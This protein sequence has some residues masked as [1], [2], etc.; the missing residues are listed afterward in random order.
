M[1][2]RL[3]ARSISLDKIKKFCTYRLPKGVKLKDFVIEDDD[4][5]QK[6]CLLGVG[7]GGLNLV[8]T[9]SKNRSN[10]HAMMAHMDYNDLGKRALSLFV[11]GHKQLYVVATLESEAHCHEAVEMIAKH[12]RCIGREVTL[13]IVEPFLLEVAHG[14]TKAINE[15]IKKLEAYTQKIVIFYH[16]DISKVN[17][18][19][20][21]MFSAIANKIRLCIE[22][23][24]CSDK[25]IDK[26]V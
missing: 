3:N 15:S 10:Y 16:E 20:M 5:S 17:M 19:K 4:N 18:T 8:E 6:H 22:E 2:S 14:H 1:D 21:E 9:I 23:T 13:I 7:R 24:K 12:L 25:H 26:G 11:K